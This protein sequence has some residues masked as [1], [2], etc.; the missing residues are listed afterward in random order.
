MTT[1]AT[2]S[3]YQ[4]V[5]RR[6][7]TLG[8]GNSLLY[9]DYDFTNIL[10]PE[11][12]VSRIPL[13][14]FYQTPPSYHNACFGVCVSNN[15]THGERLVSQYRALGA[16][17]V[18]EVSPS[19]LTRWHI[20]GDGTPQR[21]ELVEPENIGDLFERHKDDWS[22]S[23]IKSLRDSSYTQ[24]LG[25]ADIG[26]WPLLDREVQVHFDKLLTRTIN[27]SI[28][29]YP[30]IKTNTSESR[31]L[32]RLIFRLITAKIMADRKHPGNWL[33]DDPRLVIKEVEDYYF[34]SERPE[35]VL[36]DTNVQHDVWYE[37]RNSFHFNN[38]SVESL[39]YVYENTLMTP[40]FRK[41]TGTHGTPPAIAEYIV[42]RLPFEDIPEIE[43]RVFEPFAGHAIFLVAS[44]GR[45][46]NLLRASK[47]IEQRHTYFKSML[48]GLEIEDFA[49]EVAR[50][51]LNE[52]D[53]PNPDGWR[54]SQ[55]DVF[56]S[57]TLEDKLSEANIVLCNPP[58]EN[59]TPAEKA[60]YPNLTSTHK[61]AEILNRVLRK[62]PRLLGFVLPRVFL[63]G[64]GYRNIR[65][66]IG[67]SYSSVEIL[68]LP[69]N[70]F[71]Y[72]AAETVLVIA[73]GGKAKPI[74]LTTG[75]VYKGHLDRFYTTYVPSYRDHDEITDSSVFAEG[76]WLPEL[77]ELWKKISHL[78]TL[79]DY[80]SPIG[81]G[82]GIE[83]NFSIK[84][85]SLDLAVSD[86]E[87]PDF[88]PGLHR[89]SDGSLEP[90]VVV[91]HKY[92]NVSPDKMRGNAFEL[93]WTQPKVIV[94][95]R[96]RSIGHWKMTAAPDFDGLRCYQSFHGIWL[97]EGVSLEAISAVLNGPLANA[98]VSAFE[99]QRDIR[100]NTLKRIPIPSFLA[101]Q[102][103][104]I[105]G[106]V[107]LYRKARVDW[108]RR[109]VSDY[110]GQEA[111]LTLMKS[112][113][114]EVLRAYDLSPKLER[115]LLDYFSG[116]NRKGPVKFLEYYPNDFKPYVPWHLY[117]SQ[118]FQNASVEATLGRLKPIN[119][120]SI[121]EMLSSLEGELDT[122]E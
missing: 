35:P 2:S 118:E 100:I 110:E 63:F 33:Q 6:L 98:Y 114:A 95:A 93:P 61:P 99:G 72:S 8:Y 10:S 54:L 121:D 15:G 115:I 74:S 40:D 45:L 69:D 26:V 103:P 111:C 41:M 112:I 28:N 62:P 122:D 107:R 30:S 116:Y 11:L 86:F 25:F 108:F 27:R 14:A 43:R 34:K 52:T 5:K 51:M 67:D 105:S 88:V 32:F 53:Y 31:K 47:T 75:E 57:D 37:I 119:D 3:I 21:I 4:D 18:F 36:E 120:V 39:A 81:I 23:R 44:L 92:L 66:L 78:K 38:L 29:K 13:A 84:G 104:V 87:R 46:G 24:Q 106:L 1:E 7:V 56:A 48:S 85:K 42:R 58:F 83:Y 19:G 97:Q 59:F 9:E 94:N 49:R 96:R 64:K 102:T 55:G 50:I 73:S 79:G 17:H 117:I 109:E 71:K 76:L 77:R 113:D 90:F 70:T 91:G 101:K 82:R 89:I 12:P 60:Y 65:K 80:I 20:A 68:G 16:P 22:P